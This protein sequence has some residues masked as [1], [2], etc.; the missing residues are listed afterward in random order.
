[1]CLYVARPAKRS[2]VA[3]VKS[4]RPH[5]KRTTCTL[6]NRVYMVYV[7]GYGRQPLSLTIL[8]NGVRG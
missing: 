4:P 1:M 8:T 3:G 5:I 6:L 2:K 7:C